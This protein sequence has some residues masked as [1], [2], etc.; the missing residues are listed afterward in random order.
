MNLL[1]L[2]FDLL[3]DLPITLSCYY[4]LAHTCKTLFQL[5]RNKLQ[6]KHQEIMEDALLYD[7]IELYKYFKDLAVS[8]YEIKIKKIV[9][10]AACGG[11]L[12]ILKWV[13]ENRND[14]YCYINS[15]RIAYFSATA[16]TEL[17]TL[18]ILQ[19]LYQINPKLFKEVID[20]ADNDNAKYGSLNPTCN[21]TAYWGKLSCLQWLDTVIVDKIANFNGVIHSAIQSGNLDLVK[22]LYKLGQNPSK[23][24]AMKNAAKT[25]NLALVQWLYEM[26]CLLDNRSWC[27]A[28]DEGHFHILEW[29][30]EKHCPW[31]TFIPYNRGKDLNIV[32]WLWNR[33]YNYNIKSLIGY[34]D[35][36]FLHILEWYLDHGLKWENDFTE[37][38]IEERGRDILKMLKKRG[39]VVKQVRVVKR[40][41]TPTTRELFKKC[42][43]LINDNGI[44]TSHS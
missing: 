10:Y 36:D 28:I 31:D 17:K 37:F 1:D 26:G 15:S 4:T 29:L 11:S 16:D 33:G 42:L 13:H 22:W 7:S 35:P 34:P 2:S 24:A 5:Y 40:G 20:G 32:E 30:H 39:L 27:A 14:N 8:G 44:Q 6:Y 3:R 19:W 23:N 43:N 41:T 21:A 12:S 38:V 18:A 25:G 9:Q